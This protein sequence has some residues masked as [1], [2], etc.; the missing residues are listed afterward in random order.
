MTDHWLRFDY[1]GVN[2]GVSACFFSGSAWL[3][4]N[5]S[6]CGQFLDYMGRWEIMTVCMP[7]EPSGFNSFINDSIPAYNTIF[8]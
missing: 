7:T 6:V 4:P 2:G 5:L 3:G 8:P 1:R